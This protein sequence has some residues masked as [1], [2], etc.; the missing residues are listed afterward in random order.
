[1][2]IW[3]PFFWEIV[4]A[5]MFEVFE[6]E[7]S[8][9]SVII[10][11]VNGCKT[12]GKLITAAWD[13]PQVDEVIVVDDGST[14][15][16]P[17]CAKEAGASV[18]TSSFMGKGASLQD[19][20]QAAKNKVLVFLDAR[21]Q[22]F[23]ADVITQLTDPILNGN[24]DLTLANAAASNASVS[25][26][27]AR[28][29]L[30]TFFP[31]LNPIE[32]PLTGIWAARR[33]LLQKLTFE[34]DYSVEVG[35][36]LEAAFQKATIEQVNVGNLKAKEESQ[37]ILTE[38]ASQVTYTI[39][40]WAD[41]QNRLKPSYVSQVEEND[42][43][44]QANLVQ[45]LQKAG[46]AE[47]LAIFSMDGVLIRGNYIL[48]LAHQVDKGAEL[49]DYLDN[50]DLKKDDL[51]K[52]IAG[53][54]AGVTSEVFKQVAHEMPLMPG[55]KETVAALRKHGYLVGIVSDSYY[56]ATEIVRCRVFGDFSIAHVMKFKGNK[57]TGRI[58]LSPV[59]TYLEG[60]PDHPHCKLNVLYHL[61]EMTGISPENILAVGS[62]ENDLCMLNAVGHSVAFRPT[63]SIVRTTAQ[64]VLEGALS[65]LIS[66]LEVTAN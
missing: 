13:H 8:L 38:M 3:S 19:G 11:V 37:E 46:P 40:A 14:D 48:E 15:D 21:L 58:N 36:L 22:G 54:F 55:A 52:K 66:E 17:E 42:R 43:Q 50:E 47:R 34:P 30:R 45:M 41:E 16:T 9:I 2:E 56:T 63:R 25:Q 31:E 29:L 6:Q 23:N 26:L 62:N 53:L 35:V 1:M 4:A 65:D 28:P 7:D 32:F 59:M 60:C 10:P 39:L 44:A 64:Q 49:A 61:S 24:V 5:L 20:V 12:V 51:A 27:T 57:A 33:S 18:I